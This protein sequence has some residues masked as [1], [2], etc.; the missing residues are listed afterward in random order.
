MTADDLAK[1]VIEAIQD[2]PEAVK[3]ISEA[4]AARD[5]VKIRDAIQQGAGIELTDEEAQTIVNIVNA[6]PTQPAAY[7]T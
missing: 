4:L 3:S 2:K 1:R 6:N 7:F 5:P